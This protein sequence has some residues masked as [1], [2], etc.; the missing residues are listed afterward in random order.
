MPKTTQEVSDIVKVA[1]A[2]KL[3]YLPRGNGTFLS[4]AIRT[5]L[6][7]PVGL[8]QGIIID[9]SRMNKITLNKDSTTATI[10]AGVTAFDIQ[11]TA[12]AHQKRILVGEAEAYLCAN[13]LSFGIIST[14]GN[15]YGWGA[16]NYTDVE[17]VDEKGNIIHHTGDTLKNPYA[18]NHGPTSLTL[19]P[20]SIVTSMTIKLHPKSSDE[21]A[22]LLPFES[23]EEAVDFSL[24]LAQ[25]K[26]RNITCNPFQ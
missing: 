19:R 8:S 2:N 12:A 22:M 17:L 20:A 6:A 25:K 23:L 18:K 9:M 14:W 21:H 16:D 4:V 26:H 15:A 1:N 24:D 3:P 13:V 11:R 7:G 10:Q 5:L